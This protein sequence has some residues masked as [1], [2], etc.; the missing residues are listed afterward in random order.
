[1]PSRKE[2][3]DARV[4]TAGDDSDRRATKSS[5]PELRRPPQAACPQCGQAYKTEESRTCEACGKTATR[6]ESVDGVHPHEA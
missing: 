3:T 6:Y 5:R 1:M 4:H 2:S